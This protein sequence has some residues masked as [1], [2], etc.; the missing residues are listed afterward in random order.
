MCRVYLGILQRYQSLL[1]QTDVYLPLQH[2]LVDHGASGTKNMS[3]HTRYVSRGCLAQCAVA[4]ITLTHV[5]KLLLCVLE[6]NH[7]LSYYLG[8]Q[9]WCTERQQ[10]LS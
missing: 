6:W 8:M 3:G 1:P 5:T 7:C 9:Y 2:G 10:P 4:I